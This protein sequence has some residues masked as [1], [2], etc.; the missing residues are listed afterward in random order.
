MPSHIIP[1]YF[2]PWAP[3]GAYH[4]YNRAVYKNRLFLTNSDHFK[5]V[6]YLKRYTPHFCT[7]YAYSF[8][9]NHFHLAVRIHSEELI[10]EKLL[11]RRKLLAAEKKFLAGDITFNQLIGNY[12]GNLFK[13]Y[14]KSFNLR[15]D[16][17]GTLFDQTVRRIRVRGDVISR[18]LIMYIHTNEVKHRVNDSFTNCMV[19][20]SYGA[21]V[22][23]V[24]AP[25]IDTS[26]VIQRFG[27][28]DSFVSRHTGYSRKYGLTLSDFDERNYFGYGQALVAD[29]PLIAFL[30]DEL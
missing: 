19:R 25:W 27:G 3:G 1:Y 22:G 15:H 21:Y 8:V 16:R 4:V 6:E 30:E 12:W 28:L 18:R 10:R 7:V 2:A 26:A 14:A 20:S 17:Y 5:F 23:G 11:A 13:S 9:I 29:A 24:D